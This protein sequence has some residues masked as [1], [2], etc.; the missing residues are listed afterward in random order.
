METKELCERAKALYAEKNYIEAVKLW[1][2]AAEQND[3]DAL[4]MLGI[5]HN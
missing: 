4:Y 3:A 5:C 1:R 2:A